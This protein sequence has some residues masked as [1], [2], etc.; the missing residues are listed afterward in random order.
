[1]IGG[2][3]VIGVGWVS[4]SYSKLEVSSRVVGLGGS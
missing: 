2:R 1:M 4:G 3:W